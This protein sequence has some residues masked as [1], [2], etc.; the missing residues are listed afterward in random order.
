M[1]FSSIVFIFY[2]LPIFFLTYYLAGDKYKNAIILLGSVF[3]YAWGA[4]K[5]IFYYWVLP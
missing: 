4:P 1:V 3:F 5:F 2:F